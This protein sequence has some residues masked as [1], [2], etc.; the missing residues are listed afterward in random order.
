MIN[1]NGK[2]IYMNVIPHGS[3]R[4]WTRTASL[5]GE[6]GWGRKVDYWK[7]L[8][9]SDTWRHSRRGHP[10]QRPSSHIQPKPAERSKEKL[11]KRG[12]KTRHGNLLH[13][14]EYPF[15]TST[16]K[17]EYKTWRQQNTQPAFF[18]TQTNLLMSAGILSRATDSL[19]RNTK[20]SRKGQGSP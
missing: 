8:P 9:S 17:A 13:G 2:S 16:T 19:I 3:S 6:P 18:W 14:C 12:V 5:G 10:S 7:T 1:S 15:E 11:D 20:S 4:R